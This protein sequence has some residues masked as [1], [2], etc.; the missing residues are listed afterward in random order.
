MPC[1]F[2]R[3]LRHY[4]TVSVHRVTPKGEE[5]AAALKAELSVV[6]K[7]DVRCFSARSPTPVLATLDVRPVMSRLS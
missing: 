5:E 7:V 2:R 1:Y 3:I 6:D 4:P